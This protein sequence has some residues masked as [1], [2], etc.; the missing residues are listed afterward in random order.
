MKIASWNINSINARLPLLLDWLKAASPDVLLLQELKCEDDKFPHFEI[1][2]AGYH[3]AAVGQKSYNGVAILSK[4]EP[5]D[6]VRGL[7]GDEADAQARYIEATVGPVRIASLYLP[8]GNPTEGGLSDKYRYKLGWMSRLYTHTQT[9]WAREA[10]VVLGGDYNVIPTEDDVYDPH[11]WA[12]DA[13]YRLETRQQFRRLLNAG[14][15]DAFRALHPDDKAA[16]TFWDYQAGAWPKNEGLRIDH[17]LLSPEA[18]DKLK[19]CGIDK[20]P[21]ARDKASDHT[22]IWCELAL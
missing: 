5:R 12:E 10:P 21:R 14:W 4:D 19:A 6:V 2:A 1:T 15:M 13:L 17:L 11:G 9:L 8:N 18:A 22:P 7:P 20:A 16:F 3:A